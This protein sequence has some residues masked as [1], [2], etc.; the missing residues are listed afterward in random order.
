M[1]NK[2]RSKKRPASRPASALQRQ[3]EFQEPQEPQ[4]PAGQPA[5]EAAAFEQPSQQTQVAAS[6]ETQVT[7]A[8]ET[9][10]TASQQ[11][12][13]TASQQTQVTASQQIQQLLVQHSQLTASQPAQPKPS[14]QT[15]Q[16]STQHSQPLVQSDPQ[17]RL[18]DPS[19]SAS[20]SAPTTAARVP[21]RRR[22]TGTERL[23][24]YECWRRVIRGFVNTIH[25]YYNIVVAQIRRPP[26]CPTSRMVPRPNQS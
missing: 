4:N 9:Q 21:K 6:R 20:S 25:R 18:L 3:E 7:A 22:I 19:C 24:Y 1:V 11:T 26:L 2:P 23:D 8:Q 15:Q 13:V 12:Q 14:L 10:V 16:S 17:P 5:Q